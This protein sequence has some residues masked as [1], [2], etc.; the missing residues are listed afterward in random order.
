MWHS[1]QDRIRSVGQGLDLS[2]RLCKLGDINFL[3]GTS[4]SS[5]FKWGE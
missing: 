4:V 3:L 1:P 2:L 5:S